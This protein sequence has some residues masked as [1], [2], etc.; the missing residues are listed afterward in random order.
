MSVV[1]SP[2]F[3][4]ATSQAPASS[5]FEQ[6]LCGLVI[7]AAPRLFAVVQVCGEGPLGADGWVVAWGLAEES[8]AAHVTGVDGRTRMTLA[9]PER[10]L[11]FFAGPPGVSA[12][13]VWLAQPGAAVLD[14]AEAA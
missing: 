11:R 5:P 13:L 9:S 6:E 4:Q 1:P 14:E 10:V 7:D 2:N 12:R 3:R 8:G